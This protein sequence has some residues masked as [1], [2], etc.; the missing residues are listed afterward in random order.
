MP[1]LRRLTIGQVLTYGLTGLIFLGLL[2]NLM[3]SS[4]DGRTSAAMFVV[5]VIQLV[6]FMVLL[7]TYSKSFVHYGLA[8]KVLIPLVAALSLLLSFVYIT[9]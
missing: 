2:I 4:V 9:A 7:V 1:D 5:L 3:L 8:A 6:G